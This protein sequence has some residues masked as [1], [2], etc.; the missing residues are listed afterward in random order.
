MFTSSPKEK[1][2]DVASNPSFKHQNVSNMFATALQPGKWPR[3]IAAETE[4]SG[5]PKPCMSEGPKK[6]PSKLSKSSCNIQCFPLRILGKR[7]KVGKSALLWPQISISLLSSSL[8]S[9]RS[10]PWKSTNVSDVT[11][12]HICT[13]CPAEFVHHQGSHSAI[14]FPAVP[15]D[16]A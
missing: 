10:Q 11:F 6:I 3:Q 9:L 13:G 5:I 7:H 4:W 14:L 1:W 15:S 16:Q 2:Q 8:L 12:G